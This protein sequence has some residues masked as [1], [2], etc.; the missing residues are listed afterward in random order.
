MQLCLC[1]CVSFSKLSMNQCRKV[2]KPRLTHIVIIILIATPQKGKLILYYFWCYWAIYSFSRSKHIT[3]QHEEHEEWKK[4]NKF[5]L[6]LSSVIFTFPF[7]LHIALTR[8]SRVCVCVLQVNTCFTT[9]LILIFVIFRVFLS[10]F[11]YHMIHFAYFV[12]RTV[13]IHFTAACILL[14]TLL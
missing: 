4:S 3:I 5:F 7:I 12:A 8:Y 13:N 9:K 2:V 14:V 6:F 1:V 10:F 11:V